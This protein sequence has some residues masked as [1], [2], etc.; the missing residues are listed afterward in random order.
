[1]ES[2]LSH[3]S[4][5]FLP[6]FPSEM[7]VIDRLKGWVWPSLKEGLREMMIPKM[8]YVPICI[9]CAHAGT[10]TSGAGFDVRA[11]GIASSTDKVQLIHNADAIVEER[12]LGP[13]GLRNPER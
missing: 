4:S 11:Y 9:S 13:P 10:G 1:M 8:T 12:A 7:S 2:H 5:I 6:R 3:L